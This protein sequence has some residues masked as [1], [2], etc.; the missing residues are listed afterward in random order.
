M[1]TK[2]LLWK[3]LEFFLNIFDPWLIESMNVKSVDIVGQLYTQ[4]SI[5]Q[6]LKRKEILTY[7]TIRMN[8]EDV[9][10]SEISQNKKTNMSMNTLK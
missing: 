5:I 9:I 3:C 1:A 8:F 6:L 7:D 10:L 4:W 2:D